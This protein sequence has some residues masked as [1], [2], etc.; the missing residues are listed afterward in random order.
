TG[1]STAVSGS[2]SRCAEK[3]SRRMGGPSGWSRVWRAARCV[4]LRYRRRS[5]GAISSE[6]SAASSAVDLF[7]AEL[8]EP[9]VQ[10]ADAD[11]ENIRRF[12]LVVIGALQ[13]EIDVSVFDFFHGRAG[14]HANRFALLRLGNRHRRRMDFRFAVGRHAERIGREVL[15]HDQS[16]TGHDRRALENVAQLAYV[17]GPGVVLK[18]VEGRRMQARDPGAMLLVDGRENGFGNRRNV[19]L[20]VT[21][22]RQENVKDVEAVVEILAQ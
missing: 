13:N 1:G 17:S 15:R 6:R 2:A 14:T 9:V 10:G 7:I 18:T 19:F 16:F 11:S 3:L 21:Q 4:R 20:P 22:R 5:A 8:A 12:R